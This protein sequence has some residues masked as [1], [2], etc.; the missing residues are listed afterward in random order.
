MSS[1]LLWL[2]SGAAVAIAAA[3]KFFSMGKKAQKAE[4]L[5][6]K[7][8]GYERNIETVGKASSAR[9]DAERDAR[10]GM[11]DDEWTRD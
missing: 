4:D 8:K 11:L 10:S 9:S 6:G 3:I 2:L 5:E 1:F 7:V